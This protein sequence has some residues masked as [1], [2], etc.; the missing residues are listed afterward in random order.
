MIWVLRAGFDGERRRQTELNR[1]LADALQ[2]NRQHAAELEATLAEVKTLRG[3][4]P[5]CSNC[6][7]VRDDEGL[8]TQIERYVS[9]HTDASFTH[10]LCPDCLRQLYPGLAQKVLDQLNAPTVATRPEAK[11]P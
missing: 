2:T 1:Q 3:L 4:L 10:S 5:I 8:W 9:R 11:T 7:A 6:K